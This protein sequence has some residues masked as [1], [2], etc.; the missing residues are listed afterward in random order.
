MM[1]DESDRPA[2]STQAKE[3]GAALALLPIAATIDYYALPSSLQ[4]QTL[5]QFAPQIVAYLALALWVSHNDH[6]LARLGLFP[7]GWKQGL[8]WGLVTG[9]ALGSVNTLIIL[10]SVPSLGY[11]ITF[12]AST[13]H[14]QLPVFVMLPWF[15][16]VIAW[17]VE[18]NFRGFILGR[19]YAW[20]DQL[21]G[22]RRPWL[23]AGIA[24]GISSFT[25]AFDPFMVNTFRHLH[26]IA[27]WDGLV[28]GLLW[29]R[30]RNLFITIV[31]HAVEVMVMYT[32]VRATLMR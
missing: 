20:G 28:W 22:S 17:F 9:L 2:H 21:L 13:P 25:F 18:V 7:H 31:A 23:V 8:G 19:L 26:W 14:A 5:V 32:S 30:T 10:L 16:S 29:V 15:I 24:V 4:S 6:R 12:L 1:A 27:V 3:R 11:D